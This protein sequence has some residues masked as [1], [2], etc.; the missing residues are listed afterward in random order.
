MRLPPLC[1]CHVLCALLLLA[2]TPCAAQAQT[3]APPET[4]LYERLGGK[5]VVSKLT[6]D[7][8]D[9]STRDPRTRR[10][11]DKVNLKR[12]KEKVEEQICALSGGPCKYTGDDMKKSHAGLDITEAEFYGFVEQLIDLL[13]DYRIGLREKN[14][15]LAILAPMKRDVVT[16]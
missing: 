4:S 6:S 9:R 3:V 1:R 12:L 14:Q 15:L 2:V 13:D 8:I 7:L 16:R 5:P 11:F 10:S